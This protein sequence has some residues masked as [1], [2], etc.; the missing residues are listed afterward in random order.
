MQGY[1]NDPEATAATVRDGW[2]H[3][4]DVGQFDEDGYILITD[5]K[6][7]LIVNSGGDNISPQRVEG[8][9]CLREEILQAMVYGDKRAYLVA[10]VVPDPEWAKAWAK[11]QGKPS[12]P[13]AL[14]ADPDFRAALM[15]AVRASESELSVIER[16][17]QIAIADEPFS[18]DNNILTPSLK[19]RRHVVREHYGT[20]LDALYKGSKS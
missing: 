11:A 10:L 2:L 17:R 7:D 1:W 14:H 6:K 5:R 3:T 15:E 8:I 16:V 12:D 9:L 20:R 13:A 4:G 18:I 19:I